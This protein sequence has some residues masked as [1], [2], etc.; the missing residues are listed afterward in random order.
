[1]AMKQAMGETDPVETPESE[2]V[3]EGRGGLRLM[4]IITIKWCMRCLTL[5]CFAGLSIA[6][7]YFLYYSDTIHETAVSIGLLVGAV[8]VLFSAYQE[9]R[10]N[11]RK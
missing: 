9:A 10:A 4:Y 7:I 1:M 8:L 2:Q 6:G 11:G 5:G 3:E